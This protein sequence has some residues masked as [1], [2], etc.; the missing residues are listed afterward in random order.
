[1]R[2]AAFEYLKPKT[3]D[4][5]LAAL[6]GSDGGT[7]ILAGGQSLV[8]MMNFRVAVPERL[9]DV[10]GLDELAYVRRDGDVVRIG[11]LARHNAVARSALVADACPLL[12]LAYHWVAHDTVK[13]R[14]TLAGNVAHADPASEMPA[15]LLVLEATMTIAS[16]RG[17]RQV[18]AADFFQGMFATALKPDEMLVEIAVPVATSAQR[19]AFAELSPR[20]GDYALAGVAIALTLDDRTIRD[21]R[22]GAC[23]IGDLAMRLGDAERHLVGRSLDRETAEAGG[24]IAATCVSPTSD[25]KASAAYRIELVRI[26]VS[27][28]LRDLADRE[29]LELGVAA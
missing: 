17:R 15:V 3:L 26:L 4:E 24:R 28:Q 7:K 10:N 19:F 5:A 14:G 1:M 29:S 8:P 12:P 27:R 13:N 18:A 6:A 20:K 9:V 25:H 16:T 23:G 21:A 22:I 11:A 2:P